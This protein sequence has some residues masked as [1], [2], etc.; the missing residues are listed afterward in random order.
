MAGCHCPETKNMNETLHKGSCDIKQ[1]K[2]G[3]SSVKSIPPK[4]L[5]QINGCIICIKLSQTDFLDL[6]RPEQD[7]VCDMH[8]YKLCGDPK[9]DRSR[10]TCVQE[11]SSC[12]ITDI[13]IENRDSDLIR[14]ST[15]QSYDLGNHKVLMI[16]RA[17]NNLPV[18]E[19]KL[20]EG[21]PCI[22][23]KEY[24]FT[25]NR[26]IYKLLDRDFYSGCQTVLNGHITFD[27]R[28]VNS[29]SSNYIP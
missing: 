24:D 7:G 13:M 27:E 20:T 19:F 8:G 16:S 11:G 3:C 18:V 9:G 23:D 1:N 26:Y 6:Q 25:K 15:Y 10:Q 5:T 12:P 28:L 22:D 4:R 21:S 2:K 14:N 17:T 29:H